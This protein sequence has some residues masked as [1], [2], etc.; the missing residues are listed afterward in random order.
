MSCTHCLN[1]GHVEDD[2]YRLIGY[3]EDFEFTNTKGYAVKGNAA[4]VTEE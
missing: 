2:C 1:T 3:P 4:Y